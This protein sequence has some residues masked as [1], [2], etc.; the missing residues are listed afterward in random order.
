MIIPLY[1]WYSYTYL[2]V[3]YVS[4][5][6]CYNYNYFTINCCHRIVFDLRLRLFPK[7]LYTPY[8]I[9]NII[10]ANTQITLF[11]LDLITTPVLYCVPRY[12]M[13]TKVHIVYRIS[14][15]LSDTTLYKTLIERRMYNCHANLLC[16][17]PLIAAKMNL[18]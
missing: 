10:C 9:I 12:T 1:L 11:L 17:I 6:N 14:I 2:C 18:Q 3:F 13:C 7:N 4:T 16:Q 15:A 8:N 5:Y